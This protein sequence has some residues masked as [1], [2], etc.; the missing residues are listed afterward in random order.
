MSEVLLAQ[1]GAGFRWQSE[2]EDGALV[3]GAGGP[4]ASAMLVDDA[5]TDCE[6]EA[7]AAHCA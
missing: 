3:G 7:C 4:D 5:T 2:V 1:V 6:S